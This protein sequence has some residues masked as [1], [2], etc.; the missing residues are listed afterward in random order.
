MQR[1]KVSIKS[2]TGIASAMRKYCDDCGIS[3]YKFLSST[4]I[5]KM[6]NPI[7]YSVEE[8]EQ[9]QQRRHDKNAE[10]E[11]FEFGISDAIIQEQLR[12]IKEDY[13]IPLSKFFEHI[14]AEKLKASGYSFDDKTLRNPV[15]K[16]ISKPKQ[17]TYAEKY[18]ESVKELEK[19][20]R[21]NIIRK[22]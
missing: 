20:I 11:V 7:D 13:G 15:R 21:M 9:M 22:N 17:K 1:Y 18:A 6:R 5:E 14:I 4:V 8:I 3:I 16:N 12:I 10:F 2:A 19:S